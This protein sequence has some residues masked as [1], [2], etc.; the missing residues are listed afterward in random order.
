MLSIDVLDK[1]S[2]QIYD[3]VP[4]ATIIVN[5]HGEIQYMNELAQSLFGYEENQL[6]QQ[7]VDQLIPFRFRD[8][9]TAHIQ[10]YVQTHQ[11][12]AMGD[13]QIL[14]ARHQLGHEFPV[15]VSLSPIQSAKGFYVVCAIRDVTERVTIQQTLQRQKQDLERSNEELERFAYVASHDL[16][17][18]LRI[19]A[20]FTQLLAKRYASKL[21]QEADE[22]IDY[23]VSGTKRMQSLINDLLSYSRV[24]THQKQ[25]DTIDLN[26]VLEQAKQNLWVL[27]EDEQATIESAQLP[28]IS[29]DRTQLIQLFQ[30]LF[31]NALKFKSDQS[32]VIKIQVKNTDE[33]FEFVVEDNGIGIDSQYADKIF[34]LFKRLHTQD[35]YAGTGIGLTI[36]K[37]IVELHG[38]R[39]WLESERGKGSRFYFTLKK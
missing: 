28:C 4:D 9:H 25:F 15:E 2:Q 17:E 14:Y 36:A 13:G 8:A 27:I 22:F 1:A 10:R 6:L 29:G 7:P 24:S 20:S 34:V 26:E 19:I 33:A 32:P 18:P 38:G 23:I 11:P 5:T 30:N 35:E 3:T 16:Q 37:K 21:D 12:R 31:S 39:I